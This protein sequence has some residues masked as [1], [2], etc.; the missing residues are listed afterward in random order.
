[1]TDALSKVAASV[2]DGQEVDWQSLAE[3]TDE[4]ATLANL[5]VVALLAERLRQLDEWAAPKNWGGFA[6]RSLMGSG[7]YADVFRAFDPNLDREVALKLFRHADSAAAERLLTEG[8]LLARV[9]H[10]NVVRVYGAARHDGLTGLWMECIDGESLQDS[11]AAGRIYGG[12]EAALIGLDLA[13]GLAGIH[14]AGVVHGDIKAANILRDARGQ[15][16][17]ADFGS[18]LDMATVGRPQPL[19]GTPLYLAPEVRDG[20]PPSVASDLYSLGVLLFFLMSGRYPLEA[21]SI[22]GLQAARA[23]GRASLRELR[24]ELDDGLLSIVEQCLADDPAKRPPGAGALAEALSAYLADGAGP[25]PQRFA[26]RR[27]VA[28]ALVLALAGSVAFLRQPAY[29]LDVDLYRLADSGAAVVVA[30]GGAVALGDSLQLNLHTDASLY[31]YV[32]SESDD[33]QTWGLFPLASL[34]LANP[35]TPDAEHRLPGDGWSWQVSQPAATETIHVV[36]STSPMP[37]V[38]QA[39]A[40]LPMAEQPEG[41]SARGIGK[42]VR[43]PAGN[44]SPDAA[45]N[46]AAAIEA[47]MREEQTSTGVSYRRITLRHRGRN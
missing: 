37:D 41:F 43:A 46:L 31:V 1:V 44:T 3:T 30:E 8:K 39:Y 32:F 23:A 21:E 16:R 14:A 18:G 9:D 2:S 33:G 13:R 25:K 40:G 29:K 36:A 22:D 19:S 26:T 34:G 6:L 28:A 5:K 24:P 42:V 7:A 20:Q 35:L 45:A 38:Q 17:I 4:P 27:V 11:V 15:I 47:A 12:R 10:P